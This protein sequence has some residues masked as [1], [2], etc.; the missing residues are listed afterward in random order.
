MDRFLN[1]PVSNFII[2]ADDSGAV[3]QAVLEEMCEEP[4]I[5]AQLQGFDIQG[6]EPSGVLVFQ[7]QSLIPQAGRNALIAFMALYVIY[8]Q[9]RS[10]PGMSKCSQMLRQQISSIIVIILNTYS[11]GQSGILTVEK[12]QGGM[13]LP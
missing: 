10:D 2:V 3:P 9:Q 6:S 7:K 8:F 1:E 5:L 4:C 12:K 13:P 11:I